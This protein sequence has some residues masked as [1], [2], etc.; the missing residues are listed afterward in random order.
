MKI[1]HKA[2]YRVKGQRR[3]IRTGFSVSHKSL[4]SLK[5]IMP[6]IDVKPNGERWAE[7]DSYE[8]SSLVSLELEQR[9]KCIEGSLQHLRDGCFRKLKY[10]L[11]DDSDR[12]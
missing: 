9:R 10:G 1:H 8:D 12:Y 3:K 6:V 4:I 2:T 11:S 7:S 5:E